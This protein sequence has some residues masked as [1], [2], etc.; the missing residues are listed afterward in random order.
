MISK[1][2]LKLLRIVVYNPGKTAEQ[3]SKI[4]WPK[5]CRC[6]GIEH[7]LTKLEKRGLILG[8]GS[9]VFVGTHVGEDVLAGR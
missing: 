4:L 6:L 2:E 7:Y 8:Y 9:G 3:L 5:P 1:V